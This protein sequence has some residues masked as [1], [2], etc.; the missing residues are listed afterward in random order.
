[1]L[2]Y[3]TFGTGNSYDASHGAYGIGSGMTAGILFTPTISGLLSQI[4]LALAYD[5][6]SRTVNV[7]LAAD[8][9]GTPGAVIDAFTVTLT[10]QFVGG[11]SNATGAYVTAISTARPVLSSGTSYWLLATADASTHAAWYYTNTGIQSLRYSTVTVPN[12]F[13]DTAPA[14]DVWEDP[15]SSP[16]PSTTLAG[17]A[18][19]GLI[20]ARRRFA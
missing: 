19:F 5:T 3:S 17:L 14:F 2:A 11:T 7:Q 13:M 12:V 1:M 20:L 18:V 10:T 4:D 6:G 9:G 15:L 16:E 8:N